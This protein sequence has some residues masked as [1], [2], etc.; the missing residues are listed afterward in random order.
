MKTLYQ[1]NNNYITAAQLVQIIGA[2][3]ATAVEKD[4]VLNITAK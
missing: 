2:K 1:G 4:G 3:G